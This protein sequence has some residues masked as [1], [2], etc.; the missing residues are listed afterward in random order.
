MTEAGLTAAVA[1]AVHDLR[2]DDLP[3]AV[4]RK[5][6]DVV[7]DALGCQLACSTLPHGR[8][9]IEFARTQ[10]GRP[11]ATVIGTDL[12]T[13]VEH[14]ALVN[15]ILG[16]GDEIDESLLGFGHA[17]AVL[18]PAVLAVGERERASG[19]EM[20]VALVA[21]YELAGRLSRAGFNLD[22][23]APRNWQ[24]ASTAGSIAAAAAAGRLLRLGTE[25]LRAAFGLAAEQACGLQAM[26]T[27]NGH[28][29]KSFHMGVGS[30]NGVASAYLAQL[31]YGGVL[32]VL[33]PP[34]SVFEAFVPAE[35][36]MPAELTRELGRRFDVLES[37]FKRYAAGSP[38]HCAIASMLAIMAAQRLTAADIADLLVRMP[39]LE[40]RLLSRSETLS[41]NL[42]YIMA[43]AAVDGRVSWEQYSDERQRD[44]IVRAL[45]QRVKVI[46]DP[47][48]DAMK[49]A[50][51]GARPAEVV[52]TTR[53]GRTFTE[54][55]LYPP[56][57]PRNPLSRE[58]LEEKFLYWSTRV[59]SRDRAMRLKTM[60]E[61]LE[62]TSDV[63]E[64][65]ALLRI[66]SA[67]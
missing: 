2:Y 60:V 47:E 65:G 40:V 22:V 32:S 66:G 51:L 1:R 26:R 20:I 10:A 16:H 67:A 46:G 6:K 3:Q 56:G 42:E 55:M 58:E 50:N 62:R 30:R 27:E 11:D 7:L 5:A 12:R 54:R 35:E 37:R 53:D 61:D 36:A 9:A 8:I 17:S 24:Q 41:V 14:A 28:M 23:I 25:R 49:R 63:N 18:V 39:A 15:G 13:S 45:W 21:G 48:M 38:T 64:L 29:N 43:V 34:W 19:R 44:P 57:H 59:I 31:G 4:V 52:L 33:E